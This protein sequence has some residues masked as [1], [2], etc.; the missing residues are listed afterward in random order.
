M[1][2][3]FR[4]GNPLGCWMIMCMFCQ[5]PDVA[6]PGVPRLRG[7]GERQ[8]SVNRGSRREEADFKNGNIMEPRHLGC[9]KG[10]KLSLAAAICAFLLTSTARAA[11]NESLQIRLNTVG[12]LPGAEKQASIAA[13]GTNFTVIRV[14]D[15]STAFT[16]KITGPA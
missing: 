12:Y 14:A 4:A 8:C 9:N 5:L 11:E 16:G 3:C 10:F 7:S 15:N 13:P 2:A 1:Q 6:P